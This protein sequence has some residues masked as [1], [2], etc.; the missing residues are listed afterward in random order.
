MCAIYLFLSPIIQK[1]IPCVFQNWSQLCITHQYPFPPPMGPDRIPQPA[2]LHPTPASP[3]PALGI[4]QHL[5][6]VLLPDLGHYT[7]LREMVST[8]THKAGVVYQGKQALGICVILQV[9]GSFLPEH[10]GNSSNDQITCKF[11]TFFIAS[12]HL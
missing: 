8:V 3:V 9:D 2:V 7:H 11:N 10:V 12:Y 5:V 4:K 6:N 1:A